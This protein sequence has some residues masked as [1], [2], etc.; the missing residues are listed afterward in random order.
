MANISLRL[1]LQN[2]H[3]WYDERLQGIRESMQK[4]SVQAYLG[5]TDENF[6]H[7]ETY[8]SLIK[9]LNDA[10]MERFNRI[11]ISGNFLYG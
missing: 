3:E 5:T 7:H 11:M 2:L 6:I 1:S 8:I 9:Q 10:Y 4:P